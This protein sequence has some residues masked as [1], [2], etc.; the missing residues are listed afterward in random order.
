[1]NPNDPDDIPIREEPEQYDALWR[2]DWE[3]PEQYDGFFV[4]DLPEH[5]Q[6][7]TEYLMELANKKEETNG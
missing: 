5:D 1:M 2:P 7:Y 4:P 3:E 6:E